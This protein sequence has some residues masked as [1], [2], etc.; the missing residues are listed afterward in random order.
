MDALFSNAL[1]EYIKTKLDK[2]SFILSASFWAR[3]SR[4]QTPAKKNNNISKKSAVTTSIFGC[5]IEVIEEQG[6][7]NNKKKQNN[8]RFPKFQQRETVL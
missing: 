6:S 5:K 4:T 1:D 3:K 8:T 2:Q 7:N